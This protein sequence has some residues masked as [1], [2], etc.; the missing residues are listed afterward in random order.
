M[1]W[2]S[3]G[4]LPICSEELRNVTEVS[5]NDHIMAQ[6]I[7]RSEGV[8]VWESVYTKKFPDPIDAMAYTGTHLLNIATGALAFESHQRSQLNQ[9]GID[10]NT[11]E[12]EIKAIIS[13]S[14]RRAG[15]RRSSRLCS[16]A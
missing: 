3:R 2:N 1:K 9:K 16:Y 13:P 10:W 12:S 14:V 7:R 15:R 4:G 8:A 11:D 5:N 6:W